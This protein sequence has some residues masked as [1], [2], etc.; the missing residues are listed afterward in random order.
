MPILLTFLIVGGVFLSTLISKMPFI[1]QN[2]IVYAIFFKKFFFFFAKLTIS[3]VL[4]TTRGP[5]YINRISNYQRVK[6]LGHF[7]TIW[8]FRMHISFVNLST[9]SINWK[10]ILCLSSA[11]DLL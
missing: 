2:D 7:S 6:I 10:E 5:S 4:K 9:T 3:F 8:K 11:L 1:K